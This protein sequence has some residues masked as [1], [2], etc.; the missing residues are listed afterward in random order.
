MAFCLVGLI[1][2]F[3]TYAAP[4][5]FQR[6][7]RREDVLTE[8]AATPSAARPA[9]RDALGDSADAVLIGNGPI[10]PRI[11]A[12]RRAMRTRFAAEAEGTAR[13]LRWLIVLVTL[14]GA[15]FGAIALGLNRR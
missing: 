7:L 12:E 10:E 15:G 11:D 5:P 1:G 9:L 13:R 4:L 14:T 3:A 8:L 6:E 2:L